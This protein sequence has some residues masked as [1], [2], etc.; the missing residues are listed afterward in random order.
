MNPTT[1]EITLGPDALDYERDQRTYSFDV[2]ISDGTPAN[3]ATVRVNITLND[4]NEPPYAD[5]PQTFEISEDAT[6]NIAAIS[7]VDPE[8]QP[9]TFTAIPPTG[10]FT[11]NTSTGAISTTGLDFETITPNPY[12]FDVEITDGTTGN[13]ITVSVRITIKDVNERPVVYPDGADTNG[14]ANYTER[15]TA[16]QIATA[17]TLTDP[18]AG[19]VTNPENGNITTVVVQINSPL[20]GTG[21]VLDVSAASGITE[22]YD[23]ATGIL[24][25]TANPP[26]TSAAMQTVLRTLTYANASYNPTSV[27]IVRITATDGGTPPLSNNPVAEIEI[28]IQ[29]LL[30]APTLTNKGMEV[31]EGGTKTILTSEL[32]ASDPDTTAA[33]LIFTITNAVDN[34]TL[35]RG[36]TPLG[37]NSTFTQADLDS[38]LISYTHND[39]ETSSDSFTFNLTDGANP[40]TGHIFTITIIGQNDP[41][42]LTTSL[43]TTAYTIANPPVQID[44]AAT[45]TDPDPTTTDFANGGLQVSLASAT[46]TTGDTLSVRNVGLG[47]ITVVGSN[48]YYNGNQIGIMSGGTGTDPLLISFTGFSP[49][50][51]AVQAL[52]QNITFANNTPTTSLSRTV[53]FIVDDGDGDTSAPQTKQ[54]S[55][56]NRPVAVNDAV[57][58]TFNT[59]QTV[60]VLAN[61]SDP[62]NHTLSITGV[63]NGAHGTVVIEGTSVRY[64]PNLNY[65]GSDS[66]TYTI[67]DGN[68][69]TATGTV[70]VTVRLHTVFLPLVVRSA[71]ADLAVDFTFTPTNPKANVPTTSI[72]VTVTNNGEVAAS[73]FWVDFYIQPSRAPQVNE[74]WY[75]LCSLDPC[76]GL[77]WYYTGTLAPGQSVVLNSNPQSPTNP[78][79]FNVNATDWRGYFAPGTQQ[80]YAYV[81]SWNRDAGGGS[82]DVNGAVLESN[83]S[84]NRT[85]KSVVL[86]PN[87]QALPLQSELQPNR[88][89]TRP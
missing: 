34:G 31:S 44:S 28:T 48:I 51:A 85:Q 81:D 11:V 60:P 46:S 21:E 33:N 83:E 7:A 71:F 20:D 76:F 23:P 67:S 78:N 9:L 43:G 29:P 27:R 10:P 72:A 22:S 53:T 58:M 24:T 12:I 68:G 30:D 66:F 55:I 36:T 42:V 57:T 59:S 62:E 3:N 65:V 16:T 1:G 45:V 47:S 4:V 88:I 69:G 84:N 26:V 40:T 39:S 61:D 70:Q 56:N 5:S 37:V 38:G 25:L 41:P 63:T 74:P 73:N 35:Y 79:G 54:I 15:A 77:A 14:T 17:L 52:V 6:G 87:A 2:V 50:V 8:N 19:A 13:E 82:R 75:E 80:L 64:T 49:S 18:E 89:F 32:S 86:A